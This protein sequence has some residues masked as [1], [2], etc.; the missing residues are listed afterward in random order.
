MITVAHAKNHRFF[1][2][3]SFLSEKTEEDESHTVTAFDEIL[4]YVDRHFS[5]RA[6]SLSLLA[7]RFSYTEK[8]LSVLFKK[9]MQIGF[10]D[11]LNR[12]RIQHAHV[13]I[14]TGYGSI[15]EIAYACGYSDPS[16]FSRIY[17][18]KTGLS[19]SKMLS[20]LDID[21]KQARTEDKEKNA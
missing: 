19:P 14:E 6:L 17:K 20:L 18:K 10:N 11:Y 21:K 16:Y 3:L 15:A 13:L 9:Q 5:D 2:A 8:Y 7:K 4:G 1:Y 12:L